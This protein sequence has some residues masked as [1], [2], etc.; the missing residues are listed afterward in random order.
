MRQIHL[1]RAAQTVIIFYHKDAHA[2]YLILRGWWTGISFFFPLIIAYG[3][4]KSMTKSQPQVHLSVISISYTI[5][6]EA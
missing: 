3:D 1:Q 2:T 4:D 6:T 5:A